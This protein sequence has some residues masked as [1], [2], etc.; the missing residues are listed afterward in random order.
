MS[1]LKSRFL[2]AFAVVLIVADMSRLA[3]GYHVWMPN[4]EKIRLIY[5]QQT[6]RVQHIHFL[7]RP[8]RCASCWWLYGRAC[9]ISYC[10]ISRSVDWR[11]RRNYIYIYAHCFRE[12]FGIKCYALVFSVY[13]ILGVVHQHL[14]SGLC[15]I[16]VTQIHGL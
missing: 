15:F 6:I 9:L 11:P 8:C 1:K 14:L 2:P 4:H 13:I 16:F 7:F 3:R 10:N 5:S 12:A